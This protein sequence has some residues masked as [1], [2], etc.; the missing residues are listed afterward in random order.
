MD[1]ND[2]PYES[3]FV[4]RQFILFLFGIPFRFATETDSEENDSNDQEACQRDDYSQQN[5][6]LLI[7]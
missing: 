5:R 2:F 7:L 3:L 4:T 1:E 6:I